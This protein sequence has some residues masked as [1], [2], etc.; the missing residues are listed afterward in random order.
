MRPNSSLKAAVI[1]WHKHTPLIKFI[2][3]RKNIWKAKAETAAMSSIQTPKSTASPPTMKQGKHANVIIYEPN[4][5]IHK[6]TPLTAAEIEAI[7]SG[8]ASLHI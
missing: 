7:E 5:I 1:N 6:Y 2:G 4:T 3:P 8:G